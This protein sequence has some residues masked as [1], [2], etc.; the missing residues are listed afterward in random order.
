MSPP[1]SSDHAA[2]SLRRQHMLAIDGVD[3]YV[4]AEAVFAVMPTDSERSVS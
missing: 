1:F 4:C 2:S 3:A